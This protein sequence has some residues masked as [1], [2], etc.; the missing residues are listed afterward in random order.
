[1][2][3]FYY[4]TS[5]DPSQGWVSAWTLRLSLR[6]C[7][8]PAPSSPSS[9]KGGALPATGWGDPRPLTPGLGRHCLKSVLMLWSLEGSI[10]GKWTSATAPLTGSV[11]VCFVW[12][13]LFPESNSNISQQDCACLSLLSRVN[14]H[15]PRK[16]AKAQ[17]SQCTLTS[18]VNII[19]VGGMGDFLHL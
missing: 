19:G 13:L 10:T 18:C 12:C 8:S 9:T 2:A 14:A 16:K 7:I 5:F 11:R 15:A 1:M 6:P 3:E 4:F 17:S